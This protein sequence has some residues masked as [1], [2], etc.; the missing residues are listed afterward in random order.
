MGDSGFV[1]FDESSQKR[2]FD[3]VGHDIRRALDVAL[4][5]EQFEMGHGLV[6]QLLKPLVELHM[7]LISTGVVILASPCLAPVGFC[8][9]E[10]A[11][12]LVV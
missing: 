12:D 11:I 10:G 6:F 1:A 7:I 8:E 9:F 2:K 4:L 3:V 5:H